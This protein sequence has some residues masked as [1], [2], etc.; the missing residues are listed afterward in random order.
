MILF[1]YGKDT[2]RSRQRMKQLIEKFKNDRDPAGYNTVRI[3]AAAERHPE[4]VLGEILAMPFLAEKRMVVV[5]SLLSSKHTQ[6]HKDV[7]AR[8]EAQ[9]MPEATIAVFWEGADAFKG[10]DASALCERLMTEKY[11]QR[12]DELSGVKYAGWIAAEIASRGGAAE[13]DAVAYLAAHTA[14]SW[15]ANSLIDQLISWRAGAAIR[16]EDVEIFLDKREE[17][18]IFALVDAVIGGQAREAYARLKEYY[19]KGEDAY[20][21]LPLLLRQ[22]RIL[23]LLRDVYDR[24]DAMGSA[25]I[26]QKLALHPFVVKKTLPLVKRTE[27][28]EFVRL[29]ED[30]LALDIGAKTGRAD[31]NTLLYALIGRLSL[32]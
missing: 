11:A 4:R 25:E 13:Q 19:R 9:A 10:K 14:D 3:D 32:R 8:I 18:N 1:L 24:E 12:F 15:Q 7:L 5:E 2:F 23:L 22:S 30:L 29:H 27:M 16:R 28:R 31:A 6:L 21:L 17:D 26:A 20:S